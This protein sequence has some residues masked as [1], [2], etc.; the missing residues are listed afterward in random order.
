MS[1]TT[2]SFDTLSLLL[3]LLFFFNVDWLIISTVTIEHLFYGI[4]KAINAH[5]CTQIESRRD[6]PH[7]ATLGNLG[8]GRT[9]TKLFFVG[10]RPLLIQRCFVHYWELVQLKLIIIR[11]FLVLSRLCRGIGLTV[12]RGRR[13]VLWDVSWVLL[14]SIKRAVCPRILHQLRVFTVHNFHLLAADLV[15]GTMFTDVAWF[16]LPEVTRC[17][18]CPEERILVLILLRLQL[19]IVMNTHSVRR[20]GL[21]WR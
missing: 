12:V 14:P 6:W 8:C 4:L 11:V 21:S 18:T 16:A 17:Q 3:L 19:L 7:D 13:L 5:W 20:E 2:S 15:I 9:I 10:P 1:E